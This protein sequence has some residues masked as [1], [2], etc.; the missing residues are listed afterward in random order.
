MPVYSLA[1]QCESVGAQGSLLRSS[2]AVHPQPARTFSADVASQE[3]AG[4][5]GHMHRSELSAWEVSR[6]GARAAVRRLSWEGTVSAADLQLPFLMADWCQRVRFLGPSGEAPRRLRS[7]VVVLAGAYPHRGVVRQACSRP[8]PHACWAASH[9]QT[10]WAS[11]VVRA[12]RGSLAFVPSPG[13]RYPGA[14]LRRPGGRLRRTFDALKRVPAPWGNPTSLL[15]ARD[16]RQLDPD[17]LRHRYSL[18]FRIRART[19]TAIAKAT[20]HQRRS[21]A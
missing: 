12:P 20:S 11:Q 21:S 4:R 5:H 2:T 6:L 8:S 17:C 9:R 19:A 15:S 18:T 7:A 1:R 14:T 16:P 10:C 3:V 13:R